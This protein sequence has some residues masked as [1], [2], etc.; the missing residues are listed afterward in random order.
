MMNKAL[1]A[2]KVWRLMMEL[3]AFWARVMKEIYFHDKDV[4]RA[5]K[6]CRPS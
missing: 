4:F 5:N 6:C 1:L 3:K 2:K